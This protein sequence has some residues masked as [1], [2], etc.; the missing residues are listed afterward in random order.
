MICYVVTETIEKYREMQSHELKL[1]LER[2]SGDRCLVMHFSEITREFID[3]VRPWAICH[4][5]GSTAHDEY[6]VLERE[7]YRWLIRE[8]G[9]PQ[10]GFCGGCQLIAEMFGGEVAP[11]RPLADGEPDLAPDYHQGSFKE[12]GV[13]P[14]RVVAGDPLFEGLDSP[15]RVWEMH[16]SEVKVLPDEF[17]LLASS[18][19]C[20]VEAMVHRD[21]PLYGTQFHPEKRQEGY[22]D[23]HRLV[24]NF[25]RIAREAMTGE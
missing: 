15:I 25:F 16:R 14:V 2:L 7:D 23:G 3:E 13:W 4:S 21:M 22:P 17:R 9:V 8:S 18:D 6:D 11:M 24:A 12:W 1:D 5:G 19:D 20:R 10:L